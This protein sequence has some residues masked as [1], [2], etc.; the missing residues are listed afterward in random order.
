MNWRRMPATCWTR[1][2]SS[3]RHVSGRSKGRWREVANSPFLPVRASGLSAHGSASAIPVLLSRPNEVARLLHGRLRGYVCS[4]CRW[5]VASAVSANASD[6]P[7]FGRMDCFVSVCAKICRRH[8]RA[9]RAAGWM[10]T[11]VALRAQGVGLARRTRPG[12]RF[13]F[14]GAPGSLQGDTRRQQIYA[15]CRHSFPGGGAI[16]RNGAR[17]S[18]CWRDRGPRFFSGPLHMKARTIPIPTRV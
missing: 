6:L 1:K 11:A 4:R 7:T 12:Q 15:A 2:S 10:T 3:P 13:A 14:M 9:P 18:E 16:T 8:R 17:A 5:T